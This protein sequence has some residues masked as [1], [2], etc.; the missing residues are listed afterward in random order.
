MSKKKFLERR[1]RMAAVERGKPLDARNYRDSIVALLRSLGVEFETH[2]S[3]DEDYDG[4]ELTWDIPY[5]RTWY[6]IKNPYGGEC[7][8]LAID[9]GF[10]VSFGCACWSF[11]P[12]TQ[13]YDNFCEMISALVEGRAAA[14]SCLVDGKDVSHAILVGEMMNDDDMRLLERIAERDYYGTN[15]DTDYTYNLN[16]SVG[17]KKRLRKLRS[18]SGWSASYVFWNPQVNKVVEFRRSVD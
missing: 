10:D 6:V 13:G 8:E 11:H 17:L 15:Q 3:E 4:F 2:W 7:L 16:A 12:T 9:Y 18:R 1:R 5:D 14:V